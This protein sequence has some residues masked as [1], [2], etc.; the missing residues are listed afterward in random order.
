MLTF[1]TESKELKISRDIHQIINEQSLCAKS[2]IEQYI[3]ASLLV[4]MYSK[5][6]SIDDA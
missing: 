5:C 2:Q 6:G 4:I 3:L 1:C